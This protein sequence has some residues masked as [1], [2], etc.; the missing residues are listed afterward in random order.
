M[1]LRSEIKRVKC[2]QRAPAK[3]EAKI[4]RGNRNLIQKRNPLRSHREMVERSGSFFVQ[5]YIFR[6]VEG[7]QPETV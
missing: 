5:T 2:S 6:T 3:S 1:P 4:Y 7:M